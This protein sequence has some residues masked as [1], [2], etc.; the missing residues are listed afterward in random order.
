MSNDKKT[1]MTPHAAARTQ[2]HTDHTKTNE[3]FKERAQR[4]AA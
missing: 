3:G 4:G 2:G 1:P